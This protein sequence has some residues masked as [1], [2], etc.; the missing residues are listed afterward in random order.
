[1]LSAL[2]CAVVPWEVWMACL[3]GLDAV[4]GIAKSIWL[5]RAP[6]RAEG[7]D[8]AHPLLGLTPAWAAS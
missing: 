7:A 3:D 4:C 6:G 1:M 5:L 2:L 8:S